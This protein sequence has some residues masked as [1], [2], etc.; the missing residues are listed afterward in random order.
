[1]RKSL[2]NNEGSLRSGFVGLLA[3]SDEDWAKTPGEGGQRPLRTSVL[4]K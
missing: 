1:M 2:H 3:V 4:L